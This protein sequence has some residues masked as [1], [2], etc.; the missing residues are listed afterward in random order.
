MRRPATSKNTSRWAVNQAYELRTGVGMA[1]RLDRHLPNARGRRRV[2]P[3]GYLE[4]QTLS[5]PL[6]IRTM[7]S[8]L[9]W[10]LE[11]LRAYCNA[12]VPLLIGSNVRG[13]KR[14]ARSCSCTPVAPTINTIV[15][16]PDSNSNASCVAF[17]GLRACLE[18]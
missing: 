6:F 2:S 10:S 13:V 17:A 9:T 11:W 15:G 3:K 4:I 8:F 18:L 14:R 16:K 7:R 5:R 1:S 12:T